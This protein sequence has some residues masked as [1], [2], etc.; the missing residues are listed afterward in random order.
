MLYQPISQIPKIKAGVDVSKTD[1][2]IAK[3]EKAKATLQI[4]QTA[5]RLYF[6]L[7]ILQKQ[8]EEAQ[9]KLS[10]AEK[11]LY[12]VESAVMAGK[13]T[14]SNEIG[15]RANLADEEQNLLKIN[16]QLEDY[17]ADLKRLTGLPLTTE[18]VLDPVSTDE[19]PASAET[20]EGSILE[21]QNSNNDIKMA[22]L[23]K[24]KAEHAVRASQ[25]S[26]LPDLGVAGGY[27]YQDG[28]TL[29]PENNT[30]IGVLMKWNLQ[31]I[32]S[33]TYIM[34]QRLFLKKQAEENLANAQEQ[35]HTDIEKAH[36]KINQS[37]ELISVANKVLTFRQ[38]DFRIQT[39]RHQ[40]GLNLEAD[41]L[42]AKAALAKA[43]SDCYAA[44]L[45]YRMAL[46][47]LKILTGR[48]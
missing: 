10:L 23:H 14:R 2:Q 45:N 15:L 40:A 28:M 17:A 5:E 21:A 41:V 12:D 9:I 7:L 43:E 13:A 38:E 6:G 33:N 19:Q 25:Y 32:V 37:A 18:V 26:Y 20:L 27:T 31:D 11:K 48:Y 30:F 4:Q 1:L 3:T 36:R 24:E 35:V 47:D 16:I 22:A 44:Q 39:D 34:R 42:T 29:Y 8:K 46:T